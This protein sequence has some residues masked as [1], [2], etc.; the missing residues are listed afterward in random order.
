MQFR[1]MEVEFDIF[2]AEDA[3]VY[4]AAVEK[5]KAGAK[6]EP[7]ESLS[8]AIRRQCNNVFTF[9]DDLFGEDFHKEVFGEKTNLLECISAFKDFVKSIDEQKKEIDILMAKVVAEKAESTLNRAA[10][11]TVVKSVKQ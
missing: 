11:R 9:F 1:N 8:G 3:E 4:E 6:A 10:R 2:D 7:G 5:V